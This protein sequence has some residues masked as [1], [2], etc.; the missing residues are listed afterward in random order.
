M[1]YNWTLG[2]GTPLVT[3]IVPQYSH[4]YNAVGQMNVYVVAY[5]QLSNKADQKIIDIQDKIVNLRVTTVVATV[6]LSTTVTVLMDAGTAVTCA[7]LD[8]GDLSTEV[9][10]LASPSTVFPH[11]YMDEGSKTVSVSCSNGVSNESAEVQQVILYPITGLTV[12]TQ[13]AEKNVNFNLQWTITQGS[14]PTVTVLFDTVDITLS[15]SCSYDIP[16]KTGTCPNVPGMP[17]GNYVVQI[18][19]SNAVSN[20]MVNVNIDVQVAISGA[21]L[22]VNLNIVNT[23]DPIEFS[24]DMTEGSAVTITWNYN[25]GS[26]LDTFQAPA[27]QD[28][29]GT[30]EMRSHAFA[31]AGV[32][33]V[34]VIVSNGVNLITLTSSDI[35]VYPRLEDIEV[36]TNSPVTFSPPGYAEIYFNETTGIPSNVVAFSIDYGDSVIKNHTL[37]ATT[38]YLH[39]YMQANTYTLDL[40][41]TNEI[42]AYHVPVTIKVIEP[43]VDMKLEVFPQHAS[44]NQTVAFKLSMYRGG[45]DIMLGWNFGDGTP[46]TQVN[47]IGKLLYSIGQVN[48]IINISK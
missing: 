19:A 41:I 21:T 33:N 11:T 18:T 48:M 10:F 38:K 16:T 9:N 46:L 30:P 5:N 27:Q 32:F 22:G 34:V 47:R 35:K 44:K 39:A 25:D 7:L 45:L 12:V 6:G 17:V 28:W 36:L 20:Q 23:D 2:D 40:T 43:I 26:P 29:S 13:N 24:V 42:Q 1:S 15:S 8:Y 31:I 3:T 37:D 14:S 4:M